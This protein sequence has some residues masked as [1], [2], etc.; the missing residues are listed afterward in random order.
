[1][2]KTDSRFVDFRAVKAAVTMEQVLAH[3]GVLDRFKRGQ[4]SLTGPCPIHNGTNPTQ[5]RV[6]I[7]KNFWNCFSQCHCGGNVL[8][9]VARKDDVP[10]MEAANRL[11][12]WFNLDRAQL[13]AGHDREHQS[14]SREQRKERTSPPGKSRGEAVP[15]TTE[16]PAQPAAKAGSS[17]KPAKEEVGPNKPLGFH[18]ELDPSHPYLVE[19][20]LTPE[21]IDA[22]GVGFC[23]KGVMAQRIAIPI[24]NAKGELVGYAGRWPGEPPTDRPK[25]RLPDGFRKAMEIYRFAEAMREPFEQPLVIVEGFF[26]AMRLWQIGVRKV[27]AL[28]GSSLS[29]AQEQMLAEALS[30]ASQVIL[31][32]DEDDA[33]REGRSGVLQRLSLRCYTRVVAFVE[34]GFQAKNLT[35]EEAILVGVLPP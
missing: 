21:T 26:D 35:A 23:A 24:N 19:R 20:G 3:Y 16:T 34:E 18:L 2:P 5:F 10:P 12:E 30:P 25:Y 14:A 11:I 33:G 6:S 27:V 22:F 28:M 29:I 1:M 13:N 9:F 7:S 32:F 31:I 4:D 15:V 8:D 17:A